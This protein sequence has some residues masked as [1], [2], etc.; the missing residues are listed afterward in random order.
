MKILVADDE[1][2][3]CVALEKML[4]ELFPEME[5]LPAAHDGMELIRSVESQRPDIAIVDIHMPRLNGLEALEVLRTKH[6]DMEM[7]IHTAYDEFDYLHRAMK[8]GATEFLVKP[9]TEELLVQVV[10]QAANKIRQK[11]AADRQ[12]NRQ[13]S[14]PD[15]Y[16]N[17]KASDTEKLLT[18]L[19]NSVMMSLLLQT[20]D[21]ESYELWRETY[22]T[23]DGAGMI[24]L[25]EAVQGV[26]AEEAAAE[27]IR[28][29]QSR[30]VCMHYG[31]R[32]TLY[33]YLFAEGV[34]D[35]A[36]FRVWSERW[37]R[38]SLLG[39]A[40]KFHCELRCG[41]SSYKHSFE[42]I[43]GALAEAEMAKNEG[44]D[45]ILRYYSREAEPHPNVILFEETAKQAAH[46]FKAE[47]SEAAARQLMETIRS[48]ALAP[49]DR[50]ASGAA[51]TASQN[52][53][54]IGY[55]LRLARMLCEMAEYLHLE[56]RKTGMSWSIQNR[57]RDVLKLYGIC[58]DDTGTESLGEEDA[59]CI[60]DATLLS[61]LMDVMGQM[62]R[63]LSRPA[64]QTSKAVES[65][66][67]YMKNNFTRDISLEETA[68]QT[69]VSRFYLGRLLKQ[70]RG[71]TF[72]ELLTDM[73]LGKALLYIEEGTA[74]NQN[75][76][77][78]TGYS[79]VEYFQQ[80]FKRKLG[81]TPGRYRKM[82]FPT[83]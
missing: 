24:V 30:C 81:I 50:A 36:G 70:E 75:I 37:L 58:L 64:I 8:I 73:R 67:W 17:E 26:F 11:K 5:I 83:F 51:S 16:R 22:H 45:G 20:P 35:E 39:I 9:V 32:K 10:S 46:I 76:S 31:L 60:P 48:A 14:R 19:N 43:S 4:G 23:G 53:I 82:L 38:E 59:V 49:G 78:L 80:V 52:G 3:E 54:H 18:L 79:S 56:L 62:D 34:T 68:D 47:G 15:R 42:K 21:L 40:E 2:I 57:V 69:R 74:T 66:L 25:V 27:L 33:L 55:G 13:G 61:Y 7:I 12:N 65:A 63:D 1:R 6:C 28:I 77:A 29:A 41:V 71:V 72:N 44:K